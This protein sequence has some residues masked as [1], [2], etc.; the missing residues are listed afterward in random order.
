MTSSNIKNFMKKFN[1]SKPTDMPDIPEEKLG[2]DGRPLSMVAQPAKGHTKRGSVTSTVSELSTASTHVPSGLGIKEVD[3]KSH[4]NDLITIPEDVQAATTF[5]PNNEYK[6]VP[7]IIEYSTARGRSRVSIREA[8]PQEAKESAGLQMPIISDVPELSHLAN[9]TGAPPV[10]AYPRIAPPPNFEPVPAV[11]AQANNAPTHPALSS[12]PPPRHPRMSHADSMRT[13]T[14]SIRTSTVSDP[15]TSIATSEDDVASDRGSLAST[16]NAPGSPPQILGASPEYQKYEFS[17]KSMN[18]SPWPAGRASSQPSTRSRGYDSIDTSRSGAPP[19]LPDSFDANQS[20]FSWHV[21]KTEKAS[22]WFTRWFIEWWAMEIASWC[23]SAVCMMI[24]IIVLWKVDGKEMP[25]WKLGVSINAFISIFS[26]FAKSALLLPTAEALGQLKW[27]W[28]R[29]REKRMMDFE[30]ID[31][32]SR[33]PWGSM[34]LL[35]KTK[36]M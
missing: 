10:G 23:F 18:N 19:S 6:A 29:N 34:M 4:A 16:L 8:T 30:V 13:S 21:S 20:R 9:A 7:S 12:H 33:G 17:E 35:A 14:T 5:G 3:E 11:A 28:F 24:I 32:A 31:S 27:S 1:V 36:G 22:N 2:P 26:G 25:K 15:R